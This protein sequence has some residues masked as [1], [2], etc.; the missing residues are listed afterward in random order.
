MREEHN[1]GGEELDG[2]EGEVAEISDGY[3]KVWK[4]FLHIYN[5]IREYRRATE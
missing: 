5:I 3:I 2:G 1:V 4:G